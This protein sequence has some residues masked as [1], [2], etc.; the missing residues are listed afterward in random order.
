MQIY[1]IK[2]AQTFKNTKDTNDNK[3]RKVRASEYVLDGI[4][5]I[6]IFKTPGKIKTT[7]KPKGNKGEQKMLK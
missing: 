7:T 5:Q 2:Y 3:H 6:K 1:I 4:M